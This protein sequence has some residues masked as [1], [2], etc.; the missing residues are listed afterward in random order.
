MRSF[1]RGGINAHEASPWCMPHRPS[2]TEIRERWI[3]YPPLKRGDRDRGGPDWPDPSHTT[4]RT[5]P[6]TAIRHD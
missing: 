5:G 4:V 1:Y 3:A 6:Y 2:G